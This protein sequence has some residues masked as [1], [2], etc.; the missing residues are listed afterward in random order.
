MPDLAFKMSMKQ[1]QAV[2]H[3]WNQLGTMGRWEEANAA[4]ERLLRVAGEAGGTSHITHW[5][6]NQ[7]QKPSSSIR[8]HATI[9]TFF[10]FI[11]PSIHLLRAALPPQPL[12]AAPGLDALSTGARQ[13]EPLHPFLPLQ[14]LRVERP[15]D[16][17]RRA[18]V[19][20][21]ALGGHVDAVGGGR[22]GEEEA[23]ELAC[24]CMHA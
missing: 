8:T 6:N 24:V 22:D 12:T 11:H 14:Q 15:A 16:L 3:L 23:D 13:L 2:H 21:E 17:E 10:S 20:V 7:R 1:F 5:N 9:V 18:F 19:G 4:C